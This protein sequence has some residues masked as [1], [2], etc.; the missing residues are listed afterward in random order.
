MPKID[1]N[2]YYDSNGAEAMDKRLTRA[3]DKF[4]ANMKELGLKLEA[5]FS[6]VDRRF[7]TIFTHLAENKNKHLQCREKFDERYRMRG[8]MT[9]QSISVMIVILINVL[10]ILRL[11]GIL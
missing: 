8:I 6:N 5:G 4:E 3:E 11:I 9:F 10:A 1:N 2:P 7:D